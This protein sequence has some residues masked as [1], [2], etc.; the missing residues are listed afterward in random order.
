MNIVRQLIASLLALQIRY[1]YGFFEIWM[2]KNGIN[3]FYFE[4]FEKQIY[5]DSFYIFG[6][7]FGQVDHL[8]NL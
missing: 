6:H 4:S 1:D 2:T 3:P 7:K 8:T 5:R